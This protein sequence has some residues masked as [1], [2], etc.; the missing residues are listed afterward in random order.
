MLQ[1][2]PGEIIIDCV[3]RIANGRR[4]KSLDFKQFPE[5]TVFSLAERYSE[6]ISATL[7]DQRKH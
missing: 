7:P 3:V 6:I 2:F 4:R 1:K 5:L